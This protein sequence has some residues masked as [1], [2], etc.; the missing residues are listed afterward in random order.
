MSGSGRK[1]NDQIQG[2]MK[3]AVNIIQDPI[4]EWVTTFTEGT[5]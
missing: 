1:T 4:P 2:L 5:K 3:G